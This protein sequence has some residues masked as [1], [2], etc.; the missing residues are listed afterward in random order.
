M[1]PF[2]NLD[3]NPTLALERDFQLI[4]HI[5]RLGFEEAWI[6][7][8]HSGGL[9]I[10]ASPELFIAE[11]AVRTR[12]VRLGTGVISMPYHHPYMVAERL[13]QLDHQLRGRL[14]FGAGAGSLATDVYTLGLEQTEIRD[15]TSQALD[16]VMRLLK[17][18]TVSCQTEQ[19]TLREARCQLPPFSRPY[20]EMVVAS[21]STPSGPRTAAKYGGGVLSLGVGTKPE[22]DFLADTW[23]HWTEACQEHG[24]VADR[25]SWRICG[26][27]HIAETRERARANVRYGIRDWMRYLRLSPAFQALS[28]DVSEMPVDELI[29]T[30]LES[31]SAVIGTPDDLIAHIENLWQRSGGF[32]CW[33]DLTPNWASFADKKTSYELIADHVV[34]HFRGLNIH[35]NASFDWAEA[36]RESLYADRIK[37]VQAEIQKWKK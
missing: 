26:P 16:V 28:R 36:K 2:H 17:G 3:T 29:D 22:G 24:T 5:D 9:E 32:G 1:P 19:Y 30:F 7:E 13:I 15:K 37:G 20:P 12:H 10:I 33:L 11:A 8:H 34:P 31:G 18:E 14:M 27:V 23:R 4:E 21:T 25:R 6:G 35:R